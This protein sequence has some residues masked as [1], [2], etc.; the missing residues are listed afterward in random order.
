M[1]ESLRDSTTDEGMPFLQH[2]E[3]LR[4]CLGLSILGVL[5]GSL[6]SFA[7]ASHLFALLTS[8]LSLAF[9]GRQLIGTGPAEAFIVKLKVSVV[10][11][12]I[13]S[14]P[15]TFLQIWNFIA[16]G[17]Y[18]KERGM[19]IPFVILSSLFFFIGISFCYYVI[20]PFA[21]Q[22]F[23]AEFNSIGIEPTIK[24]GEYL[25]FAVK[26][27]MVFGIVFE[28]PI[29]SYF[30]AKMGLVTHGWLIKKARYAILVIF[31]TAA[32][33]TPPDVATQILLALPLIVLYGICIAVAFFTERAINK[34]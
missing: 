30:L 19:A 6:I 31:I 12:I 20:F 27:L 17:L 33:L 21:F 14:A 3:E 2:L 24:I 23:L 10:A 11:G 15:F 29:L 22:F 1:S 8:P 28:L 34:A 25:A 4:K 16:P 18:E 13:L 7:F 26:L 32:I 9:E 5:I